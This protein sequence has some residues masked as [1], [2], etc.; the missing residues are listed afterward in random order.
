M[1]I[2]ACYKIAYILKPHGLKGGVTLSL[3]PE[4]PENFD[5]VQ[6]VFIQKNNQLIPHFIES[7]SVRGDKAFVKFEDVNT[8]EG[9]QSIS[10][11]AVFLPKSARPKS[12]RGAFYD[13]EIIGFEVTDTEAGI[14]GKVVEVIEAGPN[15]LLS[16][17][18]HGKEVLIPL[19]S[20]FII[21]INKSKKKIAVEL[22]EGFLEI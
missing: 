10:K 4:A 2:N 3:D 19:N 15:K 11:A 6:T 7:V 12:G 21:S 9:A 1:D 8:Q 17:D 16:V 14:L 5:E 18:H 13:D 20:P 22:P